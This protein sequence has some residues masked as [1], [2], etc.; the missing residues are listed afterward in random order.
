MQPFS[1]LTAVAAPLD[2]AK[3]DTGVILPGRFMRLRRMPGVLDY[4]NAFV[5]D[6]R[7][8][9]KDRP[10]ADFVLNLPPYRGAAILVTGM[11]FG[12]GSSREGAAYAVLDFG[13]RALI[14]PSFG[15]VF[16]GNCLQN[17]IV[18]AVLPIA[19]VRELWRQLKEKPGAQITVDLV[20]Q[21]VVAPDGTRFEF[22]IDAT[23]KERLLKGLDDVGVTLEHLSQI[24]AFEAAYRRRMPWRA[25]RI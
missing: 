7:F 11:D 15:D 21:T 5:H 12:C 14:G 4:A 18:P 2:I 24:E 23:R 9:E 16:V 8:D 3:I 25:S 1:T 22:A 13:V 10:R 19:A 17:G 20:D 6:L